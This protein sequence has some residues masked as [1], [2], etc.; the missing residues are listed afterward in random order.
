VNC[1]HAP[2]VDECPPRDSTSPRSAPTG[3]RVY[4]SSFT[5][6]T[7]RIH[8]RR[9]RTRIHSTHQASLVITPA[10]LAAL[11]RAAAPSQSVGAYISP[12]ALVAVQKGSKHARGRRIQRPAGAESLRTHHLARSRGRPS[13]CS[14]S[15]L[16]LGVIVASPATVKL[17]AYNACLRGSRIAFKL[18]TDT[19]SAGTCCPPA[20]RQLNDGVAAPYG[21][22]NRAA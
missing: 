5:R 2:T 13:S 12:K 3:I 8:T 9:S 15:S 6:F 17:N 1:N 22:A 19:F 21:V 4:A 18:I 20:R 7:P 16:Q 11:S 14:C 10:A